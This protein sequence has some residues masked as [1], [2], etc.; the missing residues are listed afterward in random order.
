MVLI[1][2]GVGKL[3]KVIRKPSCLKKPQA[4]SRTDDTPKDRE[5]IVRKILSIRLFDAPASVTAPDVTEGDE[6]K[7][8]QKSSAWRASVKDIQGEVLC[9]MCPQSM[10][11]W[12]PECCSLIR[13][14]LTRQ[15]TVS[16]FT[17]MAKVEKGSKPGEL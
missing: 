16:Q 12:T 10:I 13:P 4:H 7:E 17:L 3:P 11:R 2:I 5:Y 6:L 9:G 1:G 15:R 8:R 14:I